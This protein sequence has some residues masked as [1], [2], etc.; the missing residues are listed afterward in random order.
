MCAGCRRCVDLCDA[1]PT[2]FELLDRFE[3]PDAG[4]LTPSEQDAVVDRCVHC[5]R[6]V[7]GCPYA[8]GRDAA[9]VDV[10]SRML[11]AT[12]MRFATG[13]LGRRHRRWARTVAHPERFRR[14]LGRLRPLADGAPGSLRRRALTWIT[15][16][17]A[18]RPIPA[19]LTAARRSV[20]DGPTDGPATAALV[21]P[22]CGVAPTGVADEVRRLLGEPGCGRVDIECCGAPSLHAGDVHRFARRAGANLRR[23]APVAAGHDLVVLHPTC[24]VTIR[25]EYPRLLG[26]P[27][28]GVVAERVVDAS[29]AVLARLAADPSPAATAAHVVYHA[30]GHAE[31]VDPTLPARRLLEA[32]GHRVTVVA[33]TDGVESLAGL[34]ADCDAV[35]APLAARWRERL[36]A[37]GGTDPVLASDGV[38]DGVG[39]DACAARHP[40][41]IVAAERSR[42]GGR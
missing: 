32:V 19:A 41:L 35:V 9:A 10:P 14:R 21:V 11:D 33:E 23:L 17:T 28:A 22:A 37:A 12:A 6:C 13:Q 42:D 16:V 38:H 30:S 5:R 36:D 15:G 18:T 25:D 34:G 26:D 31:A 8:P 1:F 29:A 7:V 24:A 40:I 27:V 4:R 3:E 39:A 20:P 2:L